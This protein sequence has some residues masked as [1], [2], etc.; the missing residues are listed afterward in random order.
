ML[1][2]QNKGGQPNQEG[3]IT[4]KGKKAAVFLLAFDT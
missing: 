3:G 1:I 4:R 2:H